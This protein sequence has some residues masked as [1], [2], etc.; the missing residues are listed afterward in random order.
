MKL[1]KYSAICPVT[2]KLYLIIR[3]SKRKK[4]KKNLKENHFFVSHCCWVFLKVVWALRS[5]CIFIVHTNFE[6]SYYTEIAQVYFLTPLTLR[7]SSSVLNYYIR[8]QISLLGVSPKL[9]ALVGSEKTALGIKKRILIKCT[10]THKQIILMKIAHGKEEVSFFR[11]Q[12]P[13]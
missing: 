6:N 13:D 3:I 10:K 1:P 2:T 8:C 4:D 12:F 5:N 11:A 7:L 9:L